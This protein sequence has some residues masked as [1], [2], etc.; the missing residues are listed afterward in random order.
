MYSARVPDGLILDG[1]NE[2]VSPDGNPDHFSPHGYLTL[3]FN[4]P[5]LTEKVLT[6]DGVEIYS[7]DLA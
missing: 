5:H 7:A 3:A 6:P 1:P 2:Y 4:G